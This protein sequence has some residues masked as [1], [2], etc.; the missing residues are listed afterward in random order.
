MKH[1]YQK[2]C[3]AT[4]SFRVL[5]SLTIEDLHS[6]VEKCGAGIEIHVH[7]QYCEKVMRT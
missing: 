6:I 5:V 4:L 1:R 2:L 3:S 7:V